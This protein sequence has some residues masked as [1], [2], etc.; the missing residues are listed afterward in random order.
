MQ[1]STSIDLEGSGPADRSGAP[2]Q[3]LLPPLSAGHFRVHGVRGSEAMS[4]PYRF[5]VLATSTAVEELDLTSWLV[6]RR[7]VLVVRTG[8]VP[9]AVHGV[10]QSVRSLGPRG[11]RHVSHRIRIVPELELLRNHRRSRIFQNLSVPEVVDRVLHHCPTR[12]ATRGTYPK[13]PYITQYEETDRAFVERLLAESGIYY[14]FE[15]PLA[16]LEQATTA[17]GDA[18]ASFGPVGEALA[19]VA[20]LIGAVA[21]KETVVFGDDPAGYVALPA[22]GPVGAAIG[23]VGLS[24]SVELGPLA[25]G[26]SSSPTLEFLQAEG[27]VTE[28]SDKITRLTHTRAIRAT[29]AEFR[30]Y[31]PD[32]PQLAMGARAPGGDLGLAASVSVGVSG[33]GVSVS[34]SVSIDP[35]G[36]VSLDAGLDVAGVASHL[37]YED[38]EHHGKFHFPEWADAR[39]EPERILRQR[40]RRAHVVEG[41][42]LVSGLAPG[43]RFTLANHAEERLNREYVVISVTHLGTD[44]QARELYSNEFEC[45]PSEVV[46]PPARPER[47]TVQAALTATVDGP[48]GEEVHVDSV[49]RIKVRFHWD[50]DG[51][52]GGASSCWIR[53]MQAWGGAQWGFQ[54]IPRV[55]MEVVV[56]FDGGD[57]D[58][59]IVIGSLYN[60][61]HPMPFALPEDRTRS[62]IRTKTFG[63]AGG[64]EL[65]FQD[66]AD[67][68]QIFVHAERDL[69][70]VVDHDHTLRVAHDERIAVARHRDESIGGNAR[71]RV[72]GEMEVSCATNHSLH[73][74]G[75]QRTVVDHALDVRVGGARSLRVDGRDD[76][77]IQGAATHHFLSTSTT[78][79]ETHQVT[80]VGRHEAPGSHALHVE[81]ASRSSASGSLELSSEQEI[82]LRVGKS[83]LRIGKDRIDFGS[84]A[85]GVIGGGAGLDASDDG[86][87][88]S[89]KG[90]AQLVAKDLVCKTEEASLALGT[91]V[92]IDGKKILMNSPEQASDE[93]KEPEP[94]TSFELVDQDG[95]PVPNHPFL[96]TFDDGTERAG[97][98]DGHGKVDLELLQGG[99]ISFPGLADVE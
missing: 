47:R 51:G 99:T 30:D 45:V 12:W 89:S 70:E 97:V 69:D 23:A 52:A 9:R 44:G 1:L 38:Y 3:L 49:G 94:P 61:T 76:V 77:A 55:G 35:T 37:D 91:E 21:L 41:T 53:P 42:S 18:L 71:C 11:R 13:R 87:K 10:V 66:A 32:R 33:L 8:N 19:G 93:T 6:G 82:V 27:L 67:R 46:Y 24:A 68:E 17:L 81:G 26:L 84:A 59:P 50:R 36:G 65:S 78:R 75:S 29:R 54:F 28:R 85:V 86:L 96:I 58:K 83:F 56:V 73:V 74:E 48:G 31:D 57:P 60:G 64:N 95:A 43:H 5:D 63:R 79:V 16:L 2:F 40:R 22:A 80:V 34:A 88:L 90:S 20:E 72:T 14:Y 39:E 92:K 98:L 25:A 7:A 62:G 15:Q 4:A